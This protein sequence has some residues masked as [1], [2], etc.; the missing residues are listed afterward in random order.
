MQNDEFTQTD[1]RLIGMNGSH[2]HVLRTGRDTE[3]CDF[4]LTE[5]ITQPESGTLESH[6]IRVNVIQMNELIIILFPD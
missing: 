6:P 3:K 1:L 4:T 5:N 2:H